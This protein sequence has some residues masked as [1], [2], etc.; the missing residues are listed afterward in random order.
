MGSGNLHNKLP[1][2]PWT[3]H[4]GLHRPMRTSLSTLQGSRASTLRA[5]H[6][7]SLGG[8]SC[9]VPARARLAALH[10]HHG[11]LAQLVRAHG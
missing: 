8:R 6:I 7:S 9:G 10:E 11:P 5:A 4:R 2:P 3:W 1:E